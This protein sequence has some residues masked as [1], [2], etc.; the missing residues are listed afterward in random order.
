M[1]PDS[2]KDIVFMI[3]AGFFITNAIIAEMIGGKII[4][5]GP[6]D[7]SIGILPWPIVFLD[8]KSVV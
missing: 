5:F 3:L 7:Q 2:R 4:S 1:N 8:R 6:F